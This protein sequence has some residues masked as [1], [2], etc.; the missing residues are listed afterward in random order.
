MK[1]LPHHIPTKI[2][3]HTQ[4]IQMQCG[5]LSNAHTQP[6][7]ARNFINATRNLNLTDHQV[8]FAMRKFKADG[9]CHINGESMAADSVVD[10]LRNQKDELSYSE[11]DMFSSGGTSGVDDLS[12]LCE[13]AMHSHQIE[14]NNLNLS[15][16]QNLFVACSW[17]TNKEHHA[18]HLSPD[19]IKLDVTEGDIAMVK[20]VMTDGDSNEIFEM[21]EAIT[22]WMPKAFRMRAGN[23]IA[24]ALSML[25]TRTIGNNSSRLL[26]LSRNIVTLFVGLVKHDSPEVQSLFEEKSPEASCLNFTAD[27]IRLAKETFGS[28]LLSTASGHSAA[29]TSDD[30][31]LMSQESH[32]SISGIIHGNEREMGIPLFPW[33]DE[34]ENEG[35]LD[36]SSL[37]DEEIV[38]A[39]DHDVAEVNEGHAM[40]AVPDSAS[41]PREGMRTFRVDAT[42]QGRNQDT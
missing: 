22:R 27:Q 6:S 28:I 9:T 26:S 37:E 7:A 20:A 39:S 29:Q 12:E 23:I 5:Q 15:P 40:F 32:V 8:C 30:V 42:N 41:S 24:L 34:A 10:W 13:E 25:Y 38:P 1:R 2:K 35:G 19:V 36:D 4:A 14:M 3:Q 18:F 31:G 21:D 17:S 11:F 16:D 33:I